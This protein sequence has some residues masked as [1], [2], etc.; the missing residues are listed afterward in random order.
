MVRN[1]EMPEPR[2]WREVM[3]LLCCHEGKSWAAFCQGCV[4]E[5]F[6]GLSPSNVSTGLIRNFLLSANVASLLSSHHHCYKGAPAAEPERWG[7]ISQWALFK[8]V[9]WIKWKACSLRLT[10]S[11]VTQWGRLA[12]SAPPWNI[13]Y[14]HLSEWYFSCGQDYPQF[15]AATWCGIWRVAATSRGKMPELPSLPHPSGTW[16]FHLGNAVA[17]HLYLDALWC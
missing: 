2:L 17:L 7:L 3:S 9:C 13:V 8:N 11:A 4:C 16:M 12:N 10:S 15:S 14:L 6:S 5:D 1:W